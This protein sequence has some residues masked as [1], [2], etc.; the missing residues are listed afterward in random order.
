VRRKQRLRGGQVLKFTCVPRGPWPSGA[1]GLSNVRN[2]AVCDSGGGGSVTVFLAFSTS[3]QLKH[4]TPL[5]ISTMDSPSFEKAARVLRPGTFPFRQQG[6]ESYG[7]VNQKYGTKFLHSTC[8]QPTA[9]VSPFPFP[10]IVE[11]YR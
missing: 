4:A 1:L 11:S 5:T 2:A 7:T 10:P 8:M 9:Q 3:V 6:T